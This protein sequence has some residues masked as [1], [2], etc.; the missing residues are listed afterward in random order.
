[1]IETASGDCNAELL[2]AFVETLKNEIEENKSSG[3]LCIFIVKFR[4]STTLTIDLK[5]V[6][7]H[8]TPFRKSQ[9]TFFLVNLKVPCK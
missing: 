5:G 9:L 8:I 3:F 7:R 1:M 2:E 4:T 6:Y